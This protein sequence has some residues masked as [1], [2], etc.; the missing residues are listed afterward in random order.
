LA[1]DGSENP[2]TA[3]PAWGRPIAAA[4]AE[5]H[6]LGRRPAGFDASVTSTVPLGS[7]LSS[8]AAFSVATVL[9]VASANGITVH[10]REAALLAQRVEQR[11]NGVPCGVM[12]QMASAC[13]RAGHALLLDCRSLTLEAVPLPDDIAVVVAHSGAARV[14]A[15]SAY[16]ERAEAVAAAANR[17]GVP[18]LRDATLEQVADD[19]LARHVVSENARVAEF[20]SALQAGDVV[21]AGS[22]MNESHQSLRDDYRVSTPE[23]DDLVARLR[24]AGAYGARLTGAGFGG[25]A[26]GL[27]AAERVAAIVAQI[28]PYYRA[29][30]VAAVDGA[31]TTP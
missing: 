15:G 28:E 29:F 10:G 18:A 20:A 26:V 6:E 2:R 9:T 3:E 13:G 19:P 1:A 24:A 23:L 17:L 16:T 7:G 8:S 11:A 4:L 30:T 5:L 25:C 21:R 31:N 27:V 22:L 14:L 12:D